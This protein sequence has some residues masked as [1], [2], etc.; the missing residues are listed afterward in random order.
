MCRD[1]LVTEMLVVVG[2]VRETLEHVVFDCPHYLWLRE[3]L[4]S[5]CR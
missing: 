4:H 3:A 1:E 2:G 5:L